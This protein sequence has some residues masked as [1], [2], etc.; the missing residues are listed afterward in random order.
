MKANSGTPG[1]AVLASMLVCGYS[2]LFQPFD[3]VIGEEGTHLGDGDFVQ[4]EQAFRLRQSLA[5]EHGVEAFEIGE[6]D[7][8]FQCGVV[9]DVALGFGV[10]VSPLLG[11]LP[12]E[13]D[14][15]QI[16]LA[17]ID[18]RGLILGDGGRDKRLFDGIGM[19]AIVD[20]GEG[21]L[22]IPTELEAL[23]FIVFEA[24]EL[25]DEVEFEFWAEP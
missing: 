17:G 15:E 11:C 10:G 8:L 7:E 20:L 16:C 2:S 13:G 25:L 1:I 21:A 6:D 5:D 18:E 9:A 24:L 4:L 3:V 14:V 19:N 23:V 22:E 12:E